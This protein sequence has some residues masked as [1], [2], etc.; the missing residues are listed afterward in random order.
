MSEERITRV[1]RKQLGK[2]KSKTDWTRVDALTDEDIERAVV[3]DPDQSF[4]TDEDF[5][6]AQDESWRSLSRSRE[7]DE[8]RTKLE[9][10]GLLAPPSGSP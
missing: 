9:L 6:A 5:H 8:C 7:R 2:M 10:L 3:D 1:S 4:W